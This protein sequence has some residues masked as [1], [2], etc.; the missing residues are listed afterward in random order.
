MARIILAFSP[1]LPMLSNFSPRP[2]PSSSL[3][4]STVFSE[5]WCLNMK[6]TESVP[7]PD[8]S[9]YAAE[10]VHFWIDAFKRASKCDRIPREGSRPVTAVER[11]LQRLWRAAVKSPHAK[12]KAIRASFSFALAC[13][14]NV[15]ASMLPSSSARSDLW[16]EGSENGDIACFLDNVLQSPITLSIS[17]RDTPMLPT[18]RCKVGMRPVFAFSRELTQLDKASSTAFRRSWASSTAAEYVSW[19]PLPSS[20]SP[21]PPVASKR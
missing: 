9:P 18:M 13:G 10:S 11:Q 3:Q 1:A 19:L 15:L 14:S 5:G 4:F 2:L 20:L 7:R 12:S 21:C 16:H 17:S 8:P 6:S